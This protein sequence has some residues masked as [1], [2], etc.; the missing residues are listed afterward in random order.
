[1]LAHTFSKAYLCLDHGWP[2]GSENLHRLEDVNHSFMPH[3]L[4]Y[5]TDGDEHTSPSNTRTD[6]HKHGKTLINYCDHNIQ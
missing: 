1:M 5:D 3:P 4:Q 2:L 6:Q